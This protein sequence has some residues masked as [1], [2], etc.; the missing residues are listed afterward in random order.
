[1][2]RQPWPDANPRIALI[3][4]GSVLAIA[5]LGVAV[6]GGVSH[7][8]D[9]AAPRAG[10]LRPVATPSPELEVRPGGDLQQ[11]RARGQARITTYGWVDPGRT[12]ARIPLT[13]AMQITASRGWSE[14]EA[15]R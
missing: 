11:V 10:R 5:L 13:R 3:G 2:S 1:M 12:V 8:F 4:I 6:A 14:P 15:S 9:H 7:L